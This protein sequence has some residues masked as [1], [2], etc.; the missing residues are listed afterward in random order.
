VYFLTYGLILPLASYMVVYGLHVLRLYLVERVARLE[1]VAIKD[2]FPVSSINIVY[3]KLRSRRHSSVTPERTAPERGQ[4]NIVNVE[5]SADGG[6]GKSKQRPA[7]L[8]SRRKG[9][10]GGGKAGPGD[11]STVPSSAEVAQNID[12]NEDPDAE[13][14][15]RLIDMSPENK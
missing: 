8:L 11:L 3:E 7:G 4:T 1:R 2:V 5:K 12:D 6:S 14:V 9:K 15:I 10:Q 13:R